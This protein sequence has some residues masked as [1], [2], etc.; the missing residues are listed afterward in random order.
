MR[1]SGRRCVK[2]M[3]RAIGSPA[4]RKLPAMVSWNVNPAMPDLCV[5]G[6]SRAPSRVGEGP[7]FGRAVASSKSSGG[8]TR[9]ST[10]RPSRS[11]ATISGTSASVT[12]P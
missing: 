3:A 6:R 8:S 12:R 1:A 5:G 2:D 4:R 11:D 9:R 10:R 7:G